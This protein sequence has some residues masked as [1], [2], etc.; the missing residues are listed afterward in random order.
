M[1]IRTRILLYNT[2][3]VLIS[4]V[5][6]LGVGTSVI[7]VWGFWDWSDS[8]GSSAKATELM[9]S[10]S[11][12]TDT[13]ESV[14]DRFSE[15][16]YALYV[17]LP[18]E[19]ATVYGDLSQ[20]TLL[21]SLEAQPEGRAKTYELGEDHVIARKL[22]PYLLLA[23]Q[24]PASRDP[25]SPK[26]LLIWFLI[27]GAAAI[28]IILPPTALKRAIFRPPSSIRA[29]LSSRRSAIP[30]TIC[31]STSRTSVTKMPPMKRPVPI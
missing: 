1:K 23:V 16:G 11:P 25:A 31:S 22:D 3:M 24:D 20:T 6:L 18:A 17:L 12:T 7:S 4:L 19:G 21:E 8:D 9:N 2:L 15:L 29:R 13:F 5:V 10:L 27:I 30:S 26:D 28:V 14:G